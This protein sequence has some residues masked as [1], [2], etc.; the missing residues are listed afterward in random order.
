MIPPR[1]PLIL[2]NVPGIQSGPGGEVIAVFSSIIAGSSDDEGGS[3][4][5]VAFDDQR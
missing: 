3:D 5:K 2:G 4:N 1:V